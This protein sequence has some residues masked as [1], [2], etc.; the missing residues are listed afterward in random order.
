MR[1]P[2][3]LVLDVAYLL[4]EGLSFAE[5]ARELEI[6]QKFVVEACGMIDQSEG[7]EEC[8]PYATINI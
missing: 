1:D 4:G 2:N 7:E 6:P 5:I 3:P 8:S